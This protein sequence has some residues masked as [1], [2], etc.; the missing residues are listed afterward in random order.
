MVTRTSPQIMIFA[1]RFGSGK[2]EIALNQAVALRDRGR[3]PYLV[4]LDIVTPYFRCRDR[5]EEMAE[6][7]VQ[8]ISPFPA[9]HRLHIPAI[10]PQI[11]GAIEQSERPVVVDLGGDE[12]GTRA[13]A[14]Y[15]PLVRNHAYAVY[16]VVN[17]YRPF[18]ET[19]SKIADA[20]YMLEQCAHL[21]ASALVSNPNLMSES[22]LETFVRGHRL[23]KQASQQIGLPIAFAVVEESLSEKIDRAEVSVEL[24]VI[25]RYLPLL[26]PSKKRNEAVGAGL[27]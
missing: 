13:L 4:D 19:P 22:S 14:P 16:F 17:P 26:G 6:L 3:N 2:T 9:G 5:A 21:P 7:G 12:Q 24:M 8:V 27:S 25:H 10:N 15:A 20:V 18:M 23:V 11:Q 1:G